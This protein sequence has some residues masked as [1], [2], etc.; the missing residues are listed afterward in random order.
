MSKQL[1]R[2]LLLL[3]VVFA[4][5]RTL[6]LVSLQPWNCWEVVEARKLNEYGWTQR[7]G[8]LLDWHYLTGVI[9]N[10]ERFNYPN[11][12]APIHWVNM[13]AQKI[14]GDWGVVF[15]TTGLGLVACL[16]GFFALRQLYL[17]EIALVGALLCTLAPSSIIYDADPNQGA[18]GAFLW[19]VAILLLASK[20]NVAWRALGLGL[21]CLIAGQMSWMAWT[22]FGTLLLG[23]FGVTWNG[24]WTTNRQPWF[25]WAFVVGGGLTVLLFL[26]Q[27]VVYTSDWQH[28]E[29]YIDKQSTEKVGFFAWA[30]RVATRVPMSLGLALVG[31]M[32][33]GGGGMLLRRIARPLELVALVY[34]PIFL[35]ASYVLRGFFY[36]EIWPYEYLVFPATILTC[37][38]LGSLKSKRIHQRTVMALLV[39][40]TAG[41]GYVFLRVSNPP[42]SSETVFFSELMAKESDKQDIIA[43]NLIEQQPPLQN[44]N[45]AGLDSSRFKADRLLRSNISSY[46]QVVGLLDN[47]Q[48]NRMTIVF[49]RTPMNPLDESLDKLLA[50][51]PC[52]G[53]ALPRQQGATPL[54]LRIRNIYWQLTGRHQVARS[55][56]ATPEDTRLDVYR[57]QLERLPNGDA[58]ITPRSSAEPLQPLP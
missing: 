40:A 51:V 24:R 38:L 42:L 18:M 45:V 4:I 19:P 2:H 52:Q 15:L 36:A 41:L 48:A 56:S 53:C 30:I 47:F 29:R 44:W 49:I 25:V 20:K 5:T 12:P 55:E 23:G 54:S 14:A 16:F 11:H 13:I 10:P 34:V 35:S 43:T 9:S 22:I 46:A 27:V 57:L 26:V 21:V 32:V 17:P 58:A 39:L 28:L 6:P 37:S 7:Q 3:L 33:V 50:T 31:G 8:A 1:T